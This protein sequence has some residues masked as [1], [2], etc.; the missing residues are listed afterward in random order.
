MK[1]GGVQV[2][3]PSEEILVLP[4]DPNP[5][6]LRALAIPNMDDFFKLCPEPKAPGKLTKDGMIPDEK[7][8]GYLSVIESHSNQRLAYMVIKTLEPS[9]IEWDTVKVD[10]PKTW[11]G[12][13][14][15]LKGAG[16]TQ[17]EVQRIIQLVLDANA[18]NEDK[19]IK[20]RENFCRGQVRAQS[21]SS[22]PSTEQGN[23]QSGTPAVVSA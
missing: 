17:I 9:Q 4:R 19:L 20:A 22:S 7:D 3:G 18:L 11:N 16:I 6:V 12:W 21:E 13:Q 15:D 2:T 23:S 5:I 10:N 1:I 14:S 8:P